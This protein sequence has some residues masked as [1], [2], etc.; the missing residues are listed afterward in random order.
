MKVISSLLVYLSKMTIH[1]FIHS[2][3]VYLGRHQRKH[4]EWF[5][6]L[7]NVERE[8]GYFSAFSQLLGLIL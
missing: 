6:Y 2:G 7:Q 4:E 1:S 3:L 8:K 5:L